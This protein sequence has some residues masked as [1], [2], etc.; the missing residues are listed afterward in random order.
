M[1]QEQFTHGYALLIGVNDNLIPNYALPAVAKD[2]AALH[3]VLTHPER[4]GYPAANVRLLNGADASRQGIYGGLSWLKERLAGAG[5]NATAVVY[6]SG[7]GAFSRDDNGYYIL[8]YDLRQ[9]LIDSLIRADELAAAIEQVRPRRL[10]VILD[11]CHAGGMSIKG[12]DLLGAGGLSKGAAPP[13]ARSVVALMRGQGRAVLSSSTAAESSYV[14][15]DRKMSVFTYHLIEALTGHA[16]DGHAAAGGATDVLVSDVMGYVTRAVPQTVRSAYNVSQTPVFE[17]SGENFPVALLLG[18][19]GLAKGERPPDPLAPPGDRAIA[20][21]P[22]P[23]NGSGKYQMS[24]DFRGAVLNI[25]SQLSHVTQAILAAPVGDAAGRADLNGL[26]AGL[27]AELEHIPVD[28]AAAAEQVAARLARLGGAL[29]DGDVEL[30]AVGCA[31]LERAADALDGVR[32]GVPAAARQL[33][34]AIRRL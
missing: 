25:E 32:P 16:L 26:I 18:G 8:P 21:A 20:G 22:P 6:Y 13:E 4:C 15:S 9:P 10:L 27:Q 29:A 17:V 1:A 33:T 12:D 34:A 11:C 30:A 23:G 5:D 24:G 31:G 7:H 2:T 14:R 19:K 3:T 28:Q